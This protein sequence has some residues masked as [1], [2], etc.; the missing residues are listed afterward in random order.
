MDLSTT[1]DNVTGT[2]L[3]ASINCRSHRALG[4]EYG[5]FVSKWL[6]LNCTHPIWGVAV[7]EFLDFIFKRVF[8]FP[9]R[10]TK[11]S[12][13]WTQR[14]VS[15]IDWDGFAHQVRDIPTP[16]LK[17]Y[18][19]DDHLIQRERFEETVDV[20]RSVRGNRVVVSFKEGG[21][22]IQKTKAKEIAVSVNGWLKTI[23]SLNE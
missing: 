16:V 7:Q 3:I 8:K 12:I 2:I 11:E 10:T 18:A 19:L 6:G 13:V 9:S 21:H 23:V 4:N 20:M 1:L 17:F 15:Y 22:N 14:R 5:F